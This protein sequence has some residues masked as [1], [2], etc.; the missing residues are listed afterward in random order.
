MLKTVQNL[1]NTGPAF[2]AYK[3]SG[4]QS[5]TSGVFTKITYDVEEFDTNLNFASSRFTPTVAGYYQV[6]AGTYLQATSGLTRCLTA[7]Y[8]NG[9]GYKNGNDNLTVST[10]E[11]RGICS[12]LVL[13]N[14]TTDFV[15]IY[16]LS[17]AV[18]PIVVTGSDNT[19]FQA[20]L[21]RTA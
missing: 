7:L 16:V 10:T 5:I 20:S 17:S 6:N 21:I 9:A 12:A 4:N 18:S 13:L 15:E 14:G 2:S 11:G 3:S 8:K 1:Q 19:Y